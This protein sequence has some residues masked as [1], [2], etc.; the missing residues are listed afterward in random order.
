MYEEYNS[1][2]QGGKCPEDDSFQLILYGSW[3]AGRGLRDWFARDW[4]GTCEHLSSTLS[5]WEEKSMKAALS[6]KI[7]WLVP[8]FLVDSVFNHNM[9]SSDLI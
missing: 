7:C 2:G 5:K 4:S 8:E 9:F 6:F 1:K 3:V